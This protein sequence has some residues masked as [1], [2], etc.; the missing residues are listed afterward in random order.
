M[1]SITAL[2]PSPEFVAI[3]EAGLREE[4][5]A[6]LFT[7]AAPL[8]PK[9]RAALLLEIRARGYLYDVR[10]HRGRL[11]VRGVDIVEA[12]RRATYREGGRV[13][14]AAKV[15]SPRGTAAAIAKM[16]GRSN[17]R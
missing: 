14:L 3:S 12:F 4:L 9:R 2:R 11:L 7:G 15:A 8:T 16:T 10:D 13:E 17:L 5:G 6:R 1:S